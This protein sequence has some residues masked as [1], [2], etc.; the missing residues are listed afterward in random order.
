MCAE[1]SS[2]SYQT[3]QVSAARQTAHIYYHVEMVFLKAQYVGELA[4]EDPLVRRSDIAA[5]YDC[6]TCKELLVRQRNHHLI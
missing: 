3:G 5:Y 4:V 2:E 1:T 6:N